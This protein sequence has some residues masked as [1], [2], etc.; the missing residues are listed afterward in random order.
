MNKIIILFAALMAFT[1]LLGGCASEIEAPTGPITATGTVTA[2]DDAFMASIGDDASSKYF[3][4][5]PPGYDANRAEG[6]PVLYLLNGFGGDETYWKDKFSVPDAMDQLIASGEVDPMI[7]VMPSGHNA[8][9][10]SFYTDALHPAVG[11]SKTHILDVVALV[12]AAYNTTVDPASR[13]IGGHSMGGYGAMNIVLSTP[14]MFSSVAVMAAPLAFNGTLAI[15][16][17]DSSYIGIL[18][19]LPMVLQETGYDTILTQTNGAGNATAWRNMMYPSPERRVTAM[20]FA[21]A[22]AFSPF[23]MGNP[24]MTTLLDSMV[25]GVDGDGNI[26]RQ[27]IGINLPLAVDGS[28]DGPTWD[29]W[30]MQ[31]P[32]VRLI[33]PGGEGANL[34]G[35][36]IYLDVGNDEPTHGLGLN[37]AHAVFA[38][39]LLGAGFTPTVTAFDG[40]D[41]I[42]GTI[43]AGHIEQTYERIKKLLI[44][45]SGQF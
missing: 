18:T 14:G 17:T 37:G 2:H 40:I 15:N 42:F 13:A 10:G 30:M 11:Q 22:A 33:T 16:P 38:G 44:W 23:D 20:M 39:A 43:P 36:N 32:L 8:L 26:I 25:A 9:G 45:Q 6:Y 34:A 5:T 24:Y 7:V 12:D 21:M 31:D 27:A 28:I 19:L 29:R 41:D 35:K 1:L 4:Y 3:V